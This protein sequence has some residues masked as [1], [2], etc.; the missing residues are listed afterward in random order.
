MQFGWL[1]KIHCN[2]LTFLLLASLLCSNILFAAGQT[3]QPGSRTAQGQEDGFEEQLRPGFGQRQRQQHKKK[4]RPVEQLDELD[5][6]QQDK[7]TQ[8]QRQAD[9][10]AQKKQEQQQAQREA[11]RRQEQEKVALQ[12]KQQEQQQRKEREAEKLAAQAKQQE[13]QR[14]LEEKLAVQAKQQQLELAKRQE[15]LRQ[16]KE[17]QRRLEQQKEQQRQQ[18]VQKLEAE[19]QKLE[20]AKNNL[21]DKLQAVQAHNQAQREQYKADLNALKSQMEALAQK[22]AEAK[23]AAQA[24]KQ[25]E[26]ELNQ[27]LNRLAEQKIAMQAEINARKAEVENRLNAVAKQEERLNLGLNNLNMQ[28][29][30]LDAALANNQKALQDMDRLLSQKEDE[31]AKLGQHEAEIQ[32]LNED[33]K[34]ENFESVSQ[35]PDLAPPAPFVLPPV[36][37]TP[38]IPQR[39]EGVFLVLPWLPNANQLW[40]PAPGGQSPRPMVTPRLGEYQ[41]LIDFI[42]QLQQIHALLPYLRKLQQA[43]DWYKNLTGIEKQVTIPLDED[44]GTRAKFRQSLR[45]RFK[46]TFNIDENKQKRKNFID[47]INELANNHFFVGENET[48]RNKNMSDAKK[49]AVVLNDGKAIDD[50][51][52]LIPFF[53]IAL[54]LS[55]QELQRFDYYSWL[56]APEY[57][58]FE[59]ILNLAPKMLAYK[60]GL[61]P[62]KLGYEQ[63]HKIMKEL[64]VFLVQPADNVRKFKLQGDFTLT[65][66]GAKK[67]HSV[68][69][70]EKKIAFIEAIMQ[71]CS[72]GQNTPIID[73]SVAS[74]LEVSNEEKGFWQ[75]HSSAVLK[76]VS[77]INF[78]TLVYGLGKQLGMPKY[79]VG[80]PKKYQ[81]LLNDALG[82]QL[83]S[84]LEEVEAQPLNPLQD[85]AIGS[86]ITL[87]R[88]F[89]DRRRRAFEAQAA[90][91]IRD[92]RQKKSA[93]Q[94]QRQANEQLLQQNKQVKAKL[95]AEWESIE[96]TYY[97]DYKKKI[98]ERFKHGDSNFNTPCI[99]QGPDKEAAGRTASQYEKYFSENKRSETVVEEYLA[100]GRKLLIED[101]EGCI[102]AD[103]KV[104]EWVQYLCRLINMRLVAYF[105]KLMEEEEEHL[106]RLQRY[107]KQ[108]VEHQA[109]L[110]RQAVM[111]EEDAAFKA[112]FDLMVADR[113]TAKEKEKKR[114]EAKNQRVLGENIE[115]IAALE[116]KKRHHL[117]QQEEQ[118]MAWIMQKQALELDILKQKEARAK[119][120]DEQSAILAA[121]AELQN[122]IDAANQ[123]LDQLAKQRFELQGLG[124]AIDE[125]GRRS[126]ADLEQQEVDLTAEVAAVHQEAEQ[127]DA[128][129]SQLGLQKEAVRQQGKKMI[130]QEQDA[131]DERKANEQAVF[132]QMNELNNDV[133]EFNK[134]LQKGFGAQG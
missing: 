58:N 82:Q 1:K 97:D 120:K 18:E 52:W 122:K 108:V 61:D 66:Q 62:K 101:S 21:Q 72:K 109:L 30:R 45:N 116:S 119:L 22:Q 56:F 121:K 47:A 105:D 73:A 33:V 89:E 110:A 32:D 92:H 71:R 65:Q 20:A 60:R 27:N 133:Q 93:M 90:E 17:Q 118:G 39:V 38:R 16:Q 103:A 59:Q 42:P 125:E 128:Q 81:E 99:I 68:D 131:I 49:A 6:Q 132:D 67:A 78:A 46:K 69:D 114:V 37:T 75:G 41:P 10:E 4:R 26:A 50:L 14:R 100:E 111:Q 3:Y 79:Q 34:L 98:V 76:A 11:Q 124:K 54:R 2:S 117:M 36:P 53:D 106:R 115:R 127:L 123:A 94:G 12:A 8:Q 102:F 51:D 134:K 44:L 85:S 86:L 23:A 107:G 95:Q 15:E 29:Q 83:L 88:S 77:S 64:I 112:L 35:W 87:L 7:V 104:V 63:A 129:A 126:L 9:R 70:V 113:K 48:K 91:Q 13:Q 25:K 57:P 24:A 80:M 43:I 40:R 28:D 19:K 84:V 74:R 31:L 96:R 5:Q 130:A 55:G